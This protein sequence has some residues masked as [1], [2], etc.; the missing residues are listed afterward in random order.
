MP[1]PPSRRF[2]QR[3]RTGRTT[4]TLPRPGTGRQQARGRSSTALR[5]TSRKTKVRG[6]NPTLGIISTV[7]FALFWVFILLAINGV[8]TSAASHD[9]GRLMAS[10]GLGL[11]SYIFPF[12]GLATGIAGLVHRRSQRVMA[13]IGVVLNGGLLVFFLVSILANHH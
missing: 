4:A 9:T 8:L 11:F 6:E 7:C 5:G 2:A 13:W 1:P 3:P 10:A 12:V